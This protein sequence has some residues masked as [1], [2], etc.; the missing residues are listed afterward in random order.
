MANKTYKARALNK[1]SILAR[2]D[3]KCPYPRCNSH[4]EIRANQDYIVNGPL[5][6]GHAEC[7]NAKIHFSPSGMGSLCGTTQN[8]RMVHEY[9]NW[10]EVT[11]K[12]CLKMKDS[13]KYVESLDSGFDWLLSFYKR[14]EE[15]IIKNIEALE[16]HAVEL[17]RFG[18]DKS[19]EIEELKGGVWKPAGTWQAKTENGSYLWTITKHERSNGTE[20][21]F[22]TF[23]APMVLAEREFMGMQKN[24]YEAESKTLEEAFAW[25]AEMAELFEIETPKYHDCGGRPRRLA[26]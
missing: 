22:K 26:K 4:G 1:R 5:G 23:A 25:A 24:V 11:C 12:K 7:V 15:D 18:I 16:Y 9:E 3:G 10:H 19:A 20:A 21:R 14:D 2:F 13:A 17:K 6:W 8:Q